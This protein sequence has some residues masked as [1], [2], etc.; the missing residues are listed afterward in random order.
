MVDVLPLP[1][2]KL[3]DFVVPLCLVKQGQPT[4]PNKGELLE[5]LQR[6]PISFG[7]ARRTHEPIKKVRSR[8]QPATIGWRSPGGSRGPY[9]IILFCRAS[10]PSA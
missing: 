8:Q 2:H 9:P 5:A 1:P 3:A 4:L 10:W 6:L 7:M